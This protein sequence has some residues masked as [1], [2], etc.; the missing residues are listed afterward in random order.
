MPIFDKEK[1][2]ENKEKRQAAR[3]AKLGAQISTETKEAGLDPAPISNAGPLGAAQKAEIDARFNKSVKEDQREG[4]AKF[5]Q[6]TKAHNIADPT[7]PSDEQLKRSLRKQKRAKL[8]DILT[9]ISRG[10]R[11]QSVDPSQ[12]RGTKIRSDREAL[13]TKYK[14]AKE[15]AK[16]KNR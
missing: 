13:Y 8:G 14:D 2:K 1:R 6:Q 5:Q 16:T 7:R 10:Y 4:L 15:A 12:F 9:G 3:D 11:G